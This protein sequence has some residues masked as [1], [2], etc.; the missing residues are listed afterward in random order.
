ME[1][2]CKRYYPYS[3]TDEWYLQ[4]FLT[5]KTYKIINKTFNNGQNWYHV[6]HEEGSDTDLFNEIEF[7]DYFLS[8]KEIRRQKLQKIK[9]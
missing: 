6:E 5:G 2:I 7:N 1:A 9:K 3:E 4:V 8:M